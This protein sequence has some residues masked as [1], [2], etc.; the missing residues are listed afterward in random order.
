MIELLRSRRGKAIIQYLIMVLVGSMMLGGIL[1][2]LMSWWNGE[3]SPS[4]LLTVNG[5]EIHE[6]DIE[7]KTNAYKDHIQ[8]AQQQFGEQAD[9]FLRML[10]YDAPPQQLAL[11]DAVNSAIIQNAAENAG[12]S[13]FDHQ[14]LNEKIADPSFAQQHLFAI[15]HPD[16]YKSLGGIDEEALQQQLNRFAMTYDDLLDKTHEALQQKLYTDLV[17]NAFYIPDHQA[18]AAYMQRH[19]SR[20]FGYVTFSRDAY[21]NTIRQEGVS[22]EALRTFFDN[23]NA[24]NKRYWVPEHRSGEYWTFTPETY[25]LSIADASIDKRYKKYKESYKKEPAQ[26]E[27]RHIFLASSPETYY[28]VQQ[29][30][31]EIAQ[32][33]QDQ[34]KIFPQ[35]AQSV[36]DAD[37]AS[38]GGYVGFVTLNNTTYPENVL[39]AAFS[40]EEDGAVSHP[41]PVD[42]GFEIVGRVSRQAATYKSRDEVADEIRAEL[43]KE[44][45]NDRFKIEANQAKQNDSIEEFIRNHNGTYHEIPSLTQ[46]EARQQHEQALF[47]RIQKVRKYVAYISDNTG[48]IVKLNDITP[49]YLPS[50]EDSKDQVRED[51]YREHAYQRLTNDVERAYNMI[52]NEDASLEQVAQA[53]NL[54]HNT[55][56]LASHNDTGWKRLEQAGLPVD[57][58]K[59]MMHEGYAVSHTGDTQGSVVVLSSI[60]PI[61]EEA[62]IEQKSSLKD[63]MYATEQNQYTN[64]FIASL[65]T[66]AT[67]SGRDELQKQMNT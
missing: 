1:P 46:R 59:R 45:F 66:H 53:Y 56:T 43:A 9:M 51:Y 55:Q 44:K 62:Y 5:Y 61:D 39:R 17:S 58:M 15:M 36:S 40:L 18:R 41:I 67:I 50:F 63:D 19:A 6:Q 64:A 42:N 33:V 10:G 26:V 20:E 24:E 23:Q 49:T 3:G 48:Y 4:S 47:N 13:Y 22:D 16:V 30:A 2:P 29:R 37:D 57:R 54:S 25:N 11:R 14:V 7:H 31:N 12:I 60:A 52:T 65:H 34:P 38:D 21:I 35:K 8:M 28:D 32:Q 27:M